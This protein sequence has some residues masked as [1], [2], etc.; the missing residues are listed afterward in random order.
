MGKKFN[1]TGVCVPKKHY[2][3]DITSKLQKIKEMIDQEE[4]FTINRGRQYG[5]TTTLL[6]LEKYLQNEYTVIS[7]SFEG[8]SEKA[9][10]TE[11]QFCIDFLSL[12]ESALEVSGHSEE[13][14]KIWQNS[15][16]DGF[17][18][19]GE[20]IRKVCRQSDKGYVLMIDEVD[21]ASNNRVFLGLLSKLREKFLARNAGKDDTFHSVILAGVYDVKNIK[22]KMIK[23]GLHEP[24]HKDVNVHNSPWNIASDF[25]VDMSFSINEISGMLEGYQQENKI[26]MNAHLLA[27]E[28]YFYTS[29]YPV[30]VSRICKYID[31]KLDKQWSINSVRES[32]RI[33]TAERENPLFRSLSQ[34]L[35]S[36]KN[37]YKLLYD[38]LISGFRRTFSVDNPAVDLAYR[39]GYITDVRER[40]KIA[41]KIFEIRLA[42]YFISKD[43]SEK[44]DFSSG[45]WYEEITKGGR[46][47]MEMCLRRFRV[48]W[49]EIYGDKKDKFVENES[50]MIFLTYLKPL[51]NG[52]GYYHIETEL[53]DE[54][55]MDLVIT[56]GKERF[57]LELKT[58]KGDE[59][60]R[61]GFE[62]LLGYMDKLSED[63]GYLLT[64]DFRKKPET[65]EPTWT[66]H[67][68]N[69]IFEVRVNKS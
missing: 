21:K 26:K 43:E 66:S 3:V 60:N 25:D 65:F 27:E 45:S 57:I 46:F 39:Y 44:N 56:Y 36:D 63:K 54:R 12:I 33:T 28:I 22:L 67:E 16:V 4:Y 5:K 38:V 9:F 58:W 18:S 61:M 1:V 11:Q 69:Q 64:F 55:R 47:N 59:Y 53:S 41:N 8:L 62:Q 10:E 51:L 30:L 34:N 48:H 14:V 13:E 23:E 40:V 19:L 6:G 17:T 68:K 29:G 50:R 31:E 37:V 2:M 20:H 7:I 32:V 42:N 24:I 35:E 49:K 15:N 52:V